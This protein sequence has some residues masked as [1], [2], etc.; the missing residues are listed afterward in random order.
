[1]GLLRAHWPLH[2]SLSGPTPNTRTLVS[3]GYT[4]DMELVQE[5]MFE[6]I[7]RRS[8][9]KDNQVW[10]TPG[11]HLDLSGRSQMGA[12]TISQEVT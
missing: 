5:K 10:L 6:S 7:L 2:P 4:V 9:C 12:V 3:W 11:R 1:M 8:S